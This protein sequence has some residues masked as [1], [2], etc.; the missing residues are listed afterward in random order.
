MTTARA[1]SDGL[2]YLLACFNAFCIQ[3]HLTSRFSPA[4]SKNLATQLPH[5]NKA[6]FWWLGVSDE[7]LRY[8]FVSLNAGLGL[9]LALPGW[10]STGLKVALALLCVGFTSDMKLKEKWL[11]HFLSHLVLLSITMAAIYVR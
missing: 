9:L 2:A 3:A 6:I 4:F 7:T 8:M 11:L 1:L 10:R 5:H